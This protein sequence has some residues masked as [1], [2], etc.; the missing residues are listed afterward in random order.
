M[1]DLASYLS[2]R[3]EMLRALDV[4]KFHAFYHKHR[5]PLPPGGW[6]DPVM[7]PLIMMHKSRLQV[8]TMTEVEKALSRD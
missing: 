3:D 7:V 8:T 1:T 5:L 4:E 2:E 6:A